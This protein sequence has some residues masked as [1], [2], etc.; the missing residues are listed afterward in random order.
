V[1][2]GKDVRETKMSRRILVGTA[3]SLA[4]FFM[5]ISSVMA[6]SSVRQPY[7]ETVQFGPPGTPSEITYLPSD[8]L[9]IEDMPWSGTY[10]G[11][12]GTGTMDVVFERITLNTATGKGT[13]FATWLITIG[14]NTIWGTANGK[15]T[16]GLTGTSEGYFRGTQG[17]GA[18]ANIEKMGTYWAN[19]ATGAQTAEGY[20]IYH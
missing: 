3:A 6:T 9:I 11:T 4:L 18:F 16:G 17:T 19:L 10:V 8:I 5:A 20:I 2:F 12:L 15:I 13:C 7:S 1:H 14:G